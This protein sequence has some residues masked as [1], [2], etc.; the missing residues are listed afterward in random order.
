MS[1]H[2]N[3]AFH[4]AL[5]GYNASL[6]AYQNAVNGIEYQGRNLQTNARVALTHLNNETLNS[7]SRATCVVRATIDALILSLD[8]DTEAQPKDARTIDATAH[9]LDARLAVLRA[10][11][12][13]LNAARK[14]LDEQFGLI[15]KEGEHALAGLRKLQGEDAAAK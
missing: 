5:A 14:A 10:A 1:T 8:I 11:I 7:G 4:A 13:N 2:T 15:I 3:A 12:G 6:E 9:A